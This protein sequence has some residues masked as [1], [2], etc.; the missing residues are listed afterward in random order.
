MLINMYY[1]HHLKKILKVFIV[2]VYIYDAETC[3]LYFN[4]IGALPDSILL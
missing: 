2:H 1:Q 4:V 3:M